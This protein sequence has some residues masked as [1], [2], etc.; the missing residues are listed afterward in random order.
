MSV[1]PTLWLTFIAGLLS[2]LSP[3]CLPL[4]P[5][6]IS[7]ISGV[8]FVTE[9]GHTFGHRFKAFAHTFFF[10]IGFS[11]VFLALGLSA[12]LL[13]H[14]F[15]AYRQEIRILGGAIIVIMGLFLSQLINPKWLMMDKKWEYHQN[16]ASY[17]GSTLVGISFAAGWT[18]CI[19]PILGSVLIFSATQPSLGIL[20]IVAYILGFAIPFFVLATTLGSVRW[21]TRYA[22]LLSKI[23]GFLMIGLGLLL[24]TNMMN[25]ITVWLIRLYGGFTGF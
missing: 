19:G 17:L 13:G 8:A 5:S 21:L 7:Y 23:G 14:L 24:M 25:K 15:I 3:C 11:I 10:V 9:E 4:Y 12:T 1:E 22:A 2:F 20:Y 16:K 18:P 6:Y